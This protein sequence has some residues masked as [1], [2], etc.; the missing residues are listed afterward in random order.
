[1]QAIASMGDNLNLGGDPEIHSGER[2]VDEDLE[3][4]L[5]E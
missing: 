2:K 1:M 3:A 5:E 4:R